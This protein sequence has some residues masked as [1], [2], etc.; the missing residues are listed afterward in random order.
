MKSVNVLINEDFTI[1]IRI[2]DSEVFEELQKYAESH[3]E[4]KDN[5]SET[6]NELK[7]VLFFEKSI[8][9]HSFLKQLTKK[10]DLEI[11]CEIYRQSVEEHR[12]LL[13]LENIKEIIEKYKGSI[14]EEYKFKV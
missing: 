9:F 14:D 5:A 8:F 1:S 6:F 3:P 12:E 7:K 13:D 2:Q 11:G 4:V 10:K